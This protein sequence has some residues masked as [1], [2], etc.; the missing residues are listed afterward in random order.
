M[1]KFA[2]I[3]HDRADAG[4]LRADTRPRHLEYLGTVTERIVV[5][6]PMGSESGDPIGSL[7]IAEFDDLAA[8][9]AFAAADPYAQAGLF[10]SVQVSPWRQVIP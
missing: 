6:G 2:I 9:R 1:P 8:A 3:G 7:I 5:A 4:S 10:E